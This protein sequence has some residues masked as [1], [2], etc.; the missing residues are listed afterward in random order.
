MRLIFILV[1]AGTLRMLSNYLNKIS[2]DD[3][4]KIEWKSIY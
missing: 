3:K 1:F 2:K 4:K